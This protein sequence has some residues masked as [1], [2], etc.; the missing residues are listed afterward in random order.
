MTPTATPWEFDV[1]LFCARPRRGSTNQPRASPWEFDV[2]R[3]QLALK[4][5]N[6]SAHG[7]ALGDFQAA[8]AAGLA[9]AS[10]SM[11]AVFSAA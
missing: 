1:E 2:A 3:F 11:S 9:S 4:G 8:E 5:Q 10:I 7:I 6:N